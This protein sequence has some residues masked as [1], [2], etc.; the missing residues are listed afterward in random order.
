MAARHL[1]GQVADLADSYVARRITRRDFIRGLLALGI[2]TSAAGAILAA[3]SPGASPSPTSGGTAPSLPAGLKGDIRFLI[4]PWTEHEVEYQEVIA[5]AFKQQNPDVNFSFK[6]FD[7]AAQL[8]EYRNSLDAGSHDIYYLDFDLIPAFGDLFEDLTPRVNDASFASEKAK[9]LLWDSLATYSDKIRGLP[10]EWA[11]V[12]MLYTNMDMVRAAGFDETFVNSWDTLVSCVEAMTTPDVYGLGVGIQ[13]GP[14]WGEWYQWMRGE[15]GSYLTPDGQDTNINLPAVVDITARVADLYRRKIAPPIGTYD[16]NTAPDAFVAG[17]LATYSTDM[18]PG[19][20]IVDKNPNFEWKM[21]PYPPGSVTDRNMFAFAGTYA[22][23][24][25]TPDKDLGWEVLKWWTNSENLAYW[26][27]LSGPYPAR[28]DAEE[29]G[30]GENA[31]PQALEAFD[32]MVER[33]VSPESFPEW[34]DAET[35]AEQQIGR[36]WTGEVTPE[37]GVANAEKAVR[38]LVLG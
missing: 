23:S 32:I 3:C 38:E 19:P 14:T 31:V 11:I 8:A 36:V 16:Y 33:T 30:Y 20:G 29:N 34:R 25:K 17:R 6:L 7:W 26:C 18:A 15:G 9:Y 21:L 22:M 4:G 10:L 27:D 2:S 28:S 37:E 35:A 12:D 24:A 13:L 1:D 5:A